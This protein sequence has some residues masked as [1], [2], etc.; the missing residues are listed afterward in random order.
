MSQA[1][2]GVW[3]HSIEPDSLIKEPRISFTIRPM[4]AATKAE[5]API[6]RIKRPEPFA[7]PIARGTHDRILF[8]TDSILASTPQSIFNDIRG[9]R[10]IKKVNYELT[11]VFGFEPEFQYTNVV[12]ISCGLNDLARYQK[13]PEV[14]ADLVVNRLK[15]CLA[16]H[17]HTDFIFTAI[18][19]TKFAWLNKAIDTFNS[20]MFDLSLNHKNFTVFDSHAVILNDRIST[21]I[22]NVID[23]N[24]NGCHLTLA[25]KK[26]ITSQLVRAVELVATTKRRA[27]LPSHFRGWFWPLREEF[28]RLCRGVSGRQHQPDAQR[29]RRSGAT[30]G[31]W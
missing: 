28:V 18:V 29:G 7:P 17:S 10:C 9:H 14:L 5:H 25:A 3:M 27:R 2:Q 26:L 24:G 1:S 23:P 6:P 21:H 13:T 31:V 30:R 19:H 22:T 20:I 16:K 12:I 15:Q 11:G 4:V 8:I